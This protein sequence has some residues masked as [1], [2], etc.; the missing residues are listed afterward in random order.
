MDRYHNLARQ[1]RVHYATGD[2]ESPSE[3]VAKTIITKE[4]S[5]AVLLEVKALHQGLPAL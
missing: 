4:T 2:K 5:K 1:A 3:L